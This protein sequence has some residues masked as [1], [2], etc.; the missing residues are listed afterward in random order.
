MKTQQ[1]SLVLS[2]ILLLA[3]VT[4]AII[5]NTKK[6]RIMVLHSYDTSYSWTRNVDKG[7]R[8]ELNKY[9][10]YSILW[11]YMSTKKHK[12]RMWLQRAGIIARKKIKEWEP[13]VLIIIDNLAQEL[14]GRY[15]VNHPRIKIVFAGINGSI[16]PY[17]YDKAANVTGILENRP[18]H[19][20]RELIAA[21]EK[22]K[23]ADNPEHTEKKIR[24]RYLLD[25]SSSVLGDKRYIDQFDW[26][27]LIYTGSFIAENYAQWQEEVLS[28]A[29]KTDYVFITNYR[30]LS[31]S[32]TDHELVPPKEVMTWSEKNS[33]VPIIG[34]NPFNVED[35][36]MLS[37]GVSPYEQGETAGHMAE[38]I[39]K[40]NIT[41]AEI[42]IV[43]NR[44]FIIA[45]RKSAIL[46]RGVVLPDIYEAFCRAT[47]TYFE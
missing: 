33:P 39:L 29:D 32:E 46:K 17:G 5:F 45:M 26:N 10:D 2:I 23:N 38:K 43:P 9:H 12:D 16:E 40:K 28:S 18:C 47:E 42:P 14:A 20:F 19:A 21:I 7:L 25:S 22:K 6:P 35:G 37:I 4:T 36:C 11:H 34:L 30:Q 1:I 15:Y 27:P 3:L 24:I 44:Q 8:R 41:P 31:R 13:D